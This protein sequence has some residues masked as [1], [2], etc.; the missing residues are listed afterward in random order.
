MQGV[1]R[2]ESWREIG[3]EVLFS[4]EWAELDVITATLNM[5]VGSCEPSQV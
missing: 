3:I 4:K 2:A 5:M 1:G